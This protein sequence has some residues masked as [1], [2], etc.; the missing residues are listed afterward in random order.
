[1]RFF[2][3]RTEI[4]TLT[5]WIFLRQE[6]RS[7]S[8]WPTVNFFGLNEQV[9]FVD[10]FGRFKCKS[11]RGN[12]VIF[13][14]KVWL[15]FQKKYKIVL[16]GNWTQV[17]HS[18]G[19]CENHYTTEDYINC[20]ISNIYQIHLEDFMWMILNGIIAK[21]HKSQL[22]WAGLELATRLV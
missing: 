14:L 17:S 11:F 13:A 2:Q 15:F 22:H 8:K 10:H 6:F 7:R 21:W 18:E 19:E 5:V 12:R 16:Q 3:K 20:Q 1:M 9:V 4:I